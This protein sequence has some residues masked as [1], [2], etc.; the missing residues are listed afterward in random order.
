M[1]SDVA[2][3]KERRDIPG[4]PEGA[5]GTLQRCAATLGS[6]HLLAA[7]EGDEFG[8]RQH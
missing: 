6:S 1:Q 5:P 7:K 2:Q 4:S 3:R 8:F